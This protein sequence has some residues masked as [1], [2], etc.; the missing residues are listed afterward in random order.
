MKLCAQKQQHVFVIY[1][2]RIP[3]RKSTSSFHQ[4]VNEAIAQHRSCCPLSN[5]PFFFSAF[6]SLF[7]QNYFLWAICKFSRLKKCDGMFAWIL[8]VTYRHKK[9]LLVVRITIH[10][11][12]CFMSVNLHIASAFKAWYMQHHCPLL[13]NEV[14]AACSCAYLAETWCATLIILIPRIYCISTVLST[15][16]SAWCWCLVRSVRSLSS[17][18]SH[19]CDSQT[20]QSSNPGPLIS[21][22][23]QTSSVTMKKGDKAGS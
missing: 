17:C 12:I 10:L 23:P 3:T 9:T 13:I 2:A 1:P 14:S 18:Q 5:F 22:A 11:F 21:M 4:N 6:L 20:H 7:F 15:C 16:S 19:L 8:V